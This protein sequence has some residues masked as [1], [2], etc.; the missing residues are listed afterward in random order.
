MTMSDNHNQENLILTLEDFAECG[1]ERVLAD[2][3]CKGYYSL[4]SAFSDAARRALDEG[5]ETHSEVLKLLAAA[6]SLVLLPDSSNEPFKPLF[7]LSNQRS[8]IPDDLTKA[9]ISFFAQLVD[10]IDDPLLKARIADLVWFLQKPRDVK[11]ALASIDSYVLIPFD[12]N[13]T[14][15]EV[16]NYWKRAICLARMLGTG[17]GDRIIKMERFIMETLLSATKSNTFLCLELAGLLRSNNL[18]KDHTLEIARKLETIGIE[19]DGDG[20]FDRS[21]GYYSEAVEWFNINGDKAKA[22][23]I[24]VTIAEN[25]VR[26]AEARCTSDNPSH[27]AAASFYEEA[28]QI[29]RTIPKT[30]RQTHQVDERLAELHDHLSELNSLAVDE[31]NV[32]RTAGIDISDQVEQARDAVK[33]KTSAEEALLA[34]CN[35]CQGADT[36]YLRETALELLQNNPLQAS[37]SMKVT[38]KDG[39]TVAIRP[40]FNFQD[41]LA[42]DNEIII[43][44]EMIRYHNTSCCF[45]VESLIRPALEVLWLEHRLCESDFVAL[46]SQSPIVPKDRKRLFGKALF[47]GYD[48]DFVTAVH[49]LA[50]QIE[51]MVRFHLKQAGVSTTTLDINGLENEKGLTALM[52]LAETTEIFGEHISFEIKALFCDS[53]G[54]NLRNELAHGLLDDEV[55]HS[56]EMI[57]AWWFGLKLVFN[58]FWNATRKPADNINENH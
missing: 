43:H 29:Y 39:R 54:W 48:G 32:V 44:Y 4:Y 10:T 52:E 38:S 34:F 27:M 55:C 18:G 33:G 9:D 3:D 16:L 53:F 36:K 51:Q 22:I 19:L 46:A 58:T 8:L 49:L 28:I 14:N 20:E 30:Q 35:L 7:V 57:Y 11:F 47:A 41:P 24:T 26:L 40:G 17:A 37:I 13:V 23:S 25:L 2:V 45:A 1:W 15:H 42:A 31:M 50:P 6:C 5:R 12:S 56:T 21:R